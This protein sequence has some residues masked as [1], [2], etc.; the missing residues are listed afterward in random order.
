M[1]PLVYKS[2]LKER[3]NRTRVK[4]ED[5]PAGRFPID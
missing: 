5:R 4:K 1:I 2:S 3:N